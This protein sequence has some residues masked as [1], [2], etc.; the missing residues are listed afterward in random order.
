MVE[1]KQIMDVALVPLGCIIMCPHDND[2]PSFSDCDGK[3]ISRITYVLLFNLIGIRYGGGDGINTF[4]LPNL[5]GRTFVGCNGAG[6]T[7]GI[8]T[9]TG[10]NLG[11]TGGSETH[12]LSVAEMPSHSHNMSQSGEH[13]HSCSEADYNDRSSFDGPSKYKAWERKD[14]HSHMKTGNAGNHTHGLANTGGFLPHNNMSP[15][16]LGR[17]IIRII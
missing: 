13:Y 9:K 15:F 11:G 14:G 16:M 12:T 6:S 5:M 1:M 8:I 3:A 10:N 4:N 7:N 17:F 2:M